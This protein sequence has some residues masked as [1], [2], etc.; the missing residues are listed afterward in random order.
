[1]AWIETLDEGQVFLPSLVLG[2]LLKGVELL[3]PAQI[4]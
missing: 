4:P 1:M 3:E 2:E